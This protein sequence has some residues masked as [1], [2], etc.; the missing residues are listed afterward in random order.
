M[1]R[2]QRTRQLRHTPSPAVG[3][4][5]EQQLNRRVQPRFD[6]L[7]DHGDG[8]ERVAQDEARQGAAVVGPTFAVVGG[9]ELDP[10]GVVDFEEE[11]EVKGPDLGAHSGLEGGA[12][13]IGEDGGEV[14]VGNEG[15]ETL[16][17]GGVGGGGGGCEAGAGVGLAGCVWRER[18]IGQGCDGRHVDVES[19]VVA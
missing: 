12:V 6:V 4:L 10:I 17:D 7:P 11:D 9:V 1:A 18:D 13:G 19:L 3:R 8:E 2:H 5:D 16:E 15:V 14:E